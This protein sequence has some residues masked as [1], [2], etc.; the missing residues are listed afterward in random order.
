MINRRQ[1]LALLLGL[2][3]AGEASAAENPW[4]TK[5][6]VGAFDGDKYLAGL[7]LKLD[8]NWKTYWRVPGAGGIPPDF[9]FTG[10]NLKSATTLM[11]TPVRLDVNGDEIIGYKDEVTFVFEVTPQDKSKSVSLALNAFLGVCETICIPVP[12]KDSL[13]LS[14]DSG[15]DAQALMFAQQRLPEI[16]TTPRVTSAMRENAALVVNFSAPVQ[17]VFVEG[18]STVYF[19]KP[20]FSADG[21]MARLS[22]SGKNL[23]ADLKA[24]NLRITM[25]DGGRGLEQMVTLV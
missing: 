15:A 18:K 20:S 9:Q 14:P 4:R 13:T 7:Q 11:P 10:E 22:I 17:D 21:L 25:I 16:L 3:F 24:A 2:P 6:L 19:K 1:S 8:P 12:I 5:L 23:D